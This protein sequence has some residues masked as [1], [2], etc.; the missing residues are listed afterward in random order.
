MCSHYQLSHQ[1]TLPRLAYPP[2]CVRMAVGAQNFDNSVTAASQFDHPEPVIAAELEPISSLFERYSSTNKLTFAQIAVR[3]LCAV[4]LSTRR[5]C[6]GYTCHNIFLF[7][8][9]ISRGWRKCARSSWRSNIQSHAKYRRQLFLPLSQNFPGHSI[10]Q[11][12]QTPS[13]LILTIP[14]PT[15]FLPARRLSNRPCQ[16]LHMS[17]LR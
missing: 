14:P 9:L 13:F 5:S 4:R 17:S 12:S 1:K 8:R 16:P 15:Q 11:R 2:P 3:C 10:P 7:A 6:L